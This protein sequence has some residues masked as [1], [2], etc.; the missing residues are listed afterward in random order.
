M[1]DDWM[2][3]AK[4]ASGRECHDR[5]SPRA[6]QRTTKKGKTKESFDT[7]SC[8]QVGGE[9]AGGNTVVS[10]ILFHMHP[11]VHAEIINQGIH[12]LLDLP[13]S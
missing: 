7:Q 3:A 1:A 9:E 5:P 8:I 2:R 12:V 10:A 11:D 4:A 13:V 6:E